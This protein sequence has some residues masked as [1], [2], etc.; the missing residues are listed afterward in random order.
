M[1]LPKPLWA[2]AK[3]AQ[4]A[5]HAASLATVP[6]GTILSSVGFQPDPKSK[7]EFLAFL[8][9]IGTVAADRHIYHVTTT[10]GLVR[11]SYPAEVAVDITVKVAGWLDADAFEI[12]DGYRC[13]VMYRTRDCMEAQV[14]SPVRCAAR[15]HRNRAR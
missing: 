14:L 15:D 3:K 10:T 11:Q 4:S 13:V 9:A 12:L 1:N 2:E 6:A 8:R 5:G 7:F